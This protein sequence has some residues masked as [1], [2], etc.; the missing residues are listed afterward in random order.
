MQK[1]GIG[2]AVTRVEDHRFTRGEGQYIE[3]VNLENEAV[4]VFVRSPHAHAR[5]VEIDKSSIEDAPGVL[6]I[7]QLTPDQRG[8]FYSIP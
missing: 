5:I 6:A 1:F 2:Q 4:G 8:R 3:D 7:W